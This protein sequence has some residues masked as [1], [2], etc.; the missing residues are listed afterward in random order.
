MVCKNIL[1]RLESERAVK[2]RRGKEERRKRWDGVSQVKYSKEEIK[3][4]SMRMK[5]E[6]QNI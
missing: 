2:V 4:K 6:K 5:G 1:F 3:T